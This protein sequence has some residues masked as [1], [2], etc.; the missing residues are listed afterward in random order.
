MVL[1]G[2]R[3]W[4]VLLGI[5]VIFILGYGTYTILVDILA[6]HP[7]WWYNATFIDLGIPI[8]NDIIDRLENKL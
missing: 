6:G 3:A 5:F 1:W 8:Q 4:Q 2:T 7:I